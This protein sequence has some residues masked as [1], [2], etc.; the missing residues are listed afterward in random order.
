MEIG[1]T[2]YPSLS[3]MQCMGRRIFFATALTILI[4]TAS[5][6]WMLF[7]IGGD[8]GTILFADAMYSVSAF[9]AAI[10]VFRCVYWIRRGP[11]LLSKAHRLGWVLV[12]CGMISSS[13]GGLYYLYLEYR[14][15]S[16]FPSYADICFN[17]FYPLVGIGLLLMPTRLRFRTRIVMDACIS[18]LSLLGV[19]WYFL[20]GPLYKAQIG[21]VAPLTLITALSYPVWDILLILAVMLIILRRSAPLLQASFILI[22]V[23]VLSDVWADSAYAYFNVFGNYQSGTFYIDPFWFVG[24]L[25]MGLAALYQYNTLLRR[26][27]QEHAPH[28]RASQPDREVVR[29][30]QLISRDRWV[31]IQN[32]LIYVPLLLLLLLT[33]YAESYK[34]NVISRWLVLFT[35]AVS[36]LTALRYLLAARENTMLLWERAQQHRVSEHL[37]R[38]STK[39]AAFLELEPLCERVVTT[40]VAD[41]GFE[42]ALLLLIEAPYRTS[43]TQAHLLAYM[44]MSR[45]ATTEPL[46]TKWCWQGND[47]LRQLMS[48]GKIVEVKLDKLV[49]MMPE[50]RQQ[51]SSANLTSLLFLPLIYQGKVLGALNVAYCDNTGLDEHDSSL[52]KSY[53]ELVATMVEHAHLYQ[54]RQEHEI[55]ARSLANMAARLNTAIVEPTEIHRVICGEAAHALRANYVLLYATEPDGS[56]SPRAVYTDTREV[57]NAVHLWPTLLPHE[58]EAQ[59]LHSLQPVTLKLRSAD[60]KEAI[61]LPAITR[62]LSAF[63]TISQARLPAVVREQHRFFTLSLRERLE[64]LGVHAA[65]LVPLVTN[66]RP[67]ALLVLARTVPSDASEKK[68]FDLA[69]LT[70]IQD[71]AE[72]AVVALTNALLYQEL[73]SAHQRLQELDNLKDQFMITASHELRTPLTSVQGYLELLAQFDDTLPQEHRQ[74][75][76]Q[77]ARWGCDELV[78]M[79]NNIM[80][81]SRLEVDAG[82]RAALMERIEVRAMIGSVIDLM[83]PHLSQSQREVYVNVP[84]QLYVW[85]DPLRLRQV[86]VN[87]SMNAL[88]Y[89]PPGSPLLYAAQGSMN[90]VPCVT[91]SIS[92]KGQGIPTEDQAK[93]FQ[94]FVRLERD[95]NS[96]IR[97]SGLGLYISRRLIEAMSGRIWVESKGIP[98]EGSTFHIQLPMTSS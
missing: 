93:L 39:L 85:A 66:G 67:I 32:S 12:G 20:I 59:A 27:Y 51:F 90:H 64:Y 25:L 63:K 31:R 30:K 56:L 61:S 76:L 37:R 84:P 17:L 34:D 83:K 87:I 8:R 41:L 60:S 68:D 88:K 4:I 24:F 92:D 43:F 73:R 23:A 77:K 10:W 28:L 44:A 9:L 29:G 79:L 19:S 15:Q 47:I 72:Q 3:D 38:I 97:G 5:M 91:M 69:D 16:P 86:L 58:P 18:T 6:L 45:G 57:S 96:P 95:M 35:V 46:L 13:I 62:P 82:I 11:L 55:F 89:S 26:A 21:Q 98:G 94:R 1:V 14:G 78:V 81:T 40:A 75:F 70:Y 50:A 49:D 54:E 42:A 74:E 7:H 48:E 36:M 33:L 22:G 52:L 53:A 80:D 2:V 65:V 71:F